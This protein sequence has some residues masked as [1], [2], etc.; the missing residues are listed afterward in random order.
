MP[1]VDTARKRKR[2][3][4]G[5]SLVP[6]CRKPLPGLKRDHRLTSGFAVG[7][8]SRGFESEIVQHCQTLMQVCDERPDTS[9]TE[10]KSGVIQCHKLI[11]YPSMFLSFLV[12]AHVRSVTIETGI[13]A[14]GLILWG[15]IFGTF[16][17][18]QP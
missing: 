16:Q 1:D 15:D 13:G 5:V 11:L 12:A 2:W 10:R 17:K 3:T 7:S 8:F 6:T 14:F 9:N 4:K 18:Y